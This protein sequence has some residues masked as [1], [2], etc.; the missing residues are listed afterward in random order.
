MLTEPVFKERHDELMQHL[1]SMDPAKLQKSYKCSDKTFAPVW[2]ELMRQKDGIYPSLSPAVLSYDGIAFR[3]LAPDVFDEQ[4]WEYARKHLLILSAA[5]GLL[6][7][8]DGIHPYRLE[9]QQKL[10]FS[11]YDY[12]K[13][14]I[15]GLLEGEPVVALASKEYT[16][17]LEPYIP[18]IHVRFFEQ[19]ENGKRSE[20]GVYAKIARGTMARWMCEENITEPDQLKNFDLLGYQYDEKAS[21]PDLIVFVREKTN[22]D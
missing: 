15:A 11:L 16:K 20:K 6:R 22:H 19:D 7:V 4:Q 17:V 10:P 18:L 12:W 8:L 13:G 21:R 9:M 2:Q 5:Y 3:S 14:D 1:M